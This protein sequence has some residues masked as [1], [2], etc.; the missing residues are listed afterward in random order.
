MSQK[1]RK[2]AGNGNRKL[3]TCRILLAVLLVLT[4][5]AGAA[6]AYNYSKWNTLFRPG[7][8]SLPAELAEKS[9][10]LSERAAEQGIVLLKNQEN[11]LPL[12]RLQINLLGAA[13]DRP[14][15]GGES[16]DGYVCVSP[17]EAL[18]EENFLVNRELSGFYEKNRITP[19]G[20][21]AGQTDFGN[22]EIPQTDYPDGLLDSA[23]DYADIACLFF[24][25]RDAAG[26]HYPADMEAWTGGDAGRH[27]LQLTQNE[28][29][30]LEAACGRFGTVIVILNTPVPMEADFLSDERIDAALWIGEP[31]GQGFRALA[32]I[33]SGRIAPE[34][35]LPDTWVRN[36]ADL[37]GQA[38]A[39]LEDSGGQ[40]WNCD[41]CTEGIYSGYRYYETRFPDAGT[42]DPDGLEAWTR[43]VAFPFGYGLTYT[44]FDRKIANVLQGGDTVHVTVHVTNTGSVPGRDTAQIYVRAPYKEGSPEK[45]DVRLAGFGKTALLQPG[46]E[47]ELEVALSL[48]DMLTWDGT[49]TAA[50]RAAWVLEKGSYG[51]LLMEDA[52]TVTDKKKLKIA[53]DLVYDD[54]G[55]GPKTG[56]RQSAAP[57]FDSMTERLA[58]VTASRADWQAFEEAG[59]ARL[60][61]LPSAD[62]ETPASSGKLSVKPADNRLRLKDL[63]D[64]EA[65]DP[66]WPALADQL[67]ASDY[68]KLLVRQ[69]DQ[70]EAVASVGK[71]FFLEARLQG[72]IRSGWA[73][74]TGT[75]FPSASLL[76]AAWDP[77]LTAAVGAQIGAEAA[78]LHTGLVRVPYAGVRRSPVSPSSMVFSEDPLLSA[79]LTVELLRGI[80]SGGICTC[81]TGFGQQSGYSGSG[82]TIFL[83]GE[84]AARELYL[85]PF[86]KAVAE[87]CVDMICTGPD[88]LD[89]TPAWQSSALMTDLLRREWGFE[90][91]A[92]ADLSCADPAGTAAGLE[93][94]TD[95]FYADR[96]KTD[97]LTADSAGADQRAALLQKAAIRVLQLAAAAEKAA[98]P[99]P[100]P[101]WLLIPAFLD[102][103]LILLLVR[104]LAGG[105]GGR[106]IPRVQITE[107]LIEDSRT[108][109]GPAEKAGGIQAQPVPEHTAAEA[110]MPVPE[111]SAQRAPRAARDLFRE[112]VEKGRGSKADPETRRALRAR[113]RRKAERVKRSAAGS[114]WTEADEEGFEYLKK[115]EGD[116]TGT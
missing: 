94:G 87:G 55:R 36:L 23:R 79:N 8:G 99:A 46:E 77:E 91:S 31:G 73:G 74:R 109:G 115:K 50:G 88:L 100:I 7:G 39:V 80:Q 42:D 56:E 10:D 21:A 20:P 11:T 58:G 62:D 27:Y 45:P 98:G 12:T 110:S 34:G 26:S 97:L 24:G 92:A 28:E 18:K 15:Y 81:L 37:P 14:F 85:R 105:R 67:S 49:G 1:R 65:D 71:P 17:E 66:A 4:V 111:A 30:L 107:T 114:E 96:A 53:E 72:G 63:Q 90:G 84:Q 33:L 48:E 83:A 16:G 2:P 108:D 113:R 3:R 29:D 44:S 13:S 101:F 75:L 102:L 68:Q 51:I 70:S 78:A 60:P 38:A 22:Y 43:A 19:A 32:G 89:D 61:A 41:V 9:A 82:H 40:E 93:A 64:R 59:Q 76:A 69:Q 86:E 35:K 52:H 6:A 116:L 25:R 54:S 103:V 95:L 104:L 47:T 106:T 5:I 57:V 112:N